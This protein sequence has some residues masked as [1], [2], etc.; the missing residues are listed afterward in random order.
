[1]TDSNYSEN[2]KKLVMNKILTAI[3]YGDRERRPPAEQQKNINN[4]SSR[5]DFIQMDLKYIH[6]DDALLETEF[7]LRYSMIYRSE[8][9]A[10]R[11]WQAM[12]KRLI[13]EYLTIKMVLNYTSGEEIRE[14]LCTN[15]E[16]FANITMLL[17]NCGT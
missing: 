7:L 5:G 2:S 14:V 9:M 13:L 11:K 15:H 6:H 4:K 3:I 8:E 17:T 12:K 1:M 16:D 10:T